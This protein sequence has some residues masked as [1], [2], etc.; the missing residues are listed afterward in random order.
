M[1]LG[2][3]KMAKCTFCGKEQDDY[4]GTFLMKN[5]GTSNYYCSMKCQKNHLKLKR[6]KRKIKWTEAFHTVREKRLAKEKERV[7]KV[8]K[9]KAEKK[10]GKKNSDKN[11]AKK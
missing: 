10:A 5:D 4:K 3:S 6:D 11:D 9:E 2:G 1:L 7:E 8:R